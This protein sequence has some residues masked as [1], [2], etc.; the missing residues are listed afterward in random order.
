MLEWCDGLGHFINRR[1][2]VIEL[3]WVNSQISQIN[4]WWLTEFRHLQL[5][6]KLWK[7]GDNAYIRF[8]N[9]FD[10]HKKSG[11]QVDWKECDDILTI[12]ALGFARWAIRKLLF[13]L[14][15]IQFNSLISF[16]FDA[17]LNPLLLESRM[18]AI[19]WIVRGEV[20]TPESANKRPVLLLLF[21][22]LFKV[23]VSHVSFLFQN[24]SISSVDEQPQICRWALAS[25]RHI[26]IL[27]FVWGEWLHCWTQRHGRHQDST[28]LLTPLLELGAAEILAVSD[29]SGGLRAEPD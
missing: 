15:R 16:I 6:V 14:S 11:S 2:R 22:P 9:W 29:P 3:N 17:S 23:L 21:P 7:E 1:D 10:V 13:A 12:S 20:Q 25:S 8:K 26:R 19:P 28:F 4:H 18:T 24:L 5:A 27:R